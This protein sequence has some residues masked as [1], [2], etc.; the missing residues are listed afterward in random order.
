LRGRQNDKV[1]DG[2]KPFVRREDDPAQYWFSIA[3]S[4]AVMAV[5]WALYFW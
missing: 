3:V 4:F 2:S 5:C 1:G